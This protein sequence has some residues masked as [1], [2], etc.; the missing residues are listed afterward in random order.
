MAGPPG[1]TK[2]RAVWQGIASLAGWPRKGTTGAV[3][4]A[5][6][7]KWAEIDIICGRIGA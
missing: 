7:L 6:A 1:W 5:N 4:N 3:D 2:R